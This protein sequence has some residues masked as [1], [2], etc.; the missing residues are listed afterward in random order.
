MLHALFLMASVISQ[1]TEAVPNDDI[2]VEQTKNGAFIFRKYPPRAKAAGEQG[3]VEFRA[4]YD[5]KGSILSCEVTKS[6][7]YKRLDVET[8]ELIVKHARFKPELLNNGKRKDGIQLGLVEWR[9][10]GAPPPE[11]GKQ[12]ELE[13]PDKIICKK[14]PRGGSL[15]IMSKQCLTK[16]EWEFQSDEARDTIGEAQRRASMRVGN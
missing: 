8:C 16:R 2:G 6:S 3:D 1:P 11:A 4:D 7:G 9:I 15:V 12:A 14:I 5:K 13:A 10:P